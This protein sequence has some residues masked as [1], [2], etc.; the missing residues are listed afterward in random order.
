ME[1]KD[2]IALMQ[3]EDYKE[4]FQAEYYQLKIR[5][6]KLHDVLVKYDAGTLEFT[7]TCGIAVLK[8]QME[9]MRNYIYW[10]EVRATMEG[11]SVKR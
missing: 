2:T 5:A 7:P 1:L 3:S 10:L 9:A 8:K 4:R 6:E 11:I